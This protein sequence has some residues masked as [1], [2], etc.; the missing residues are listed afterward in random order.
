MMVSVNHQM[1][2]TL[3]FAHASWQL[4]VGQ[5]IPIDLT[6]DGR[7][8][9]H[10][11]AQVVQP[12]MAAAQMPDNS[13]L[14]RLFRGATQMSVFA[15]GRLF[16]FNLT[17]TSQVLPALVDCVRQN[18]GMPRVASAPPPIVVPPKVPV[19]NVSTLN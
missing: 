9:F 1:A 8:P 15:Q 5:V 4:Q 14:I 11:F 7:G 12:T 19:S 16:N 10:A 17:S 13:Q 6:F 3:G 2:W 18:T